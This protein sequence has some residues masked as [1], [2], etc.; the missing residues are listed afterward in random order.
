M[1]HIDVVP[2]V[3]LFAAM[4]LLLVLAFRLSAFLTRRAICYILKTFRG[5]NAIGAENARTLEE[6]GLAEQP[7]LRLTRDYKPFAFLILSQTG[8]VQ[9]TE[10]RK[11]Y[12]VEENLHMVGAE[13]F[14]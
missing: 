12:L 9:A 3:L 8:I 5:E 7:R 6:L 14:Y 13:C 2:T 4:L 1:E 11:F 10:D